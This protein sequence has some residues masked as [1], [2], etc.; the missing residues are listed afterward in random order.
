MAS[1]RAIP[2]ASVVGPSV[3]RPAACLCVC[4]SVCLLTRLFGVRS[5]GRSLSRGDEAQRRQSMRPVSTLSKHREC[6]VGREYREAG[7]RRSM[8]TSCC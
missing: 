3:F 8:R 6:N 5:I 1:L 7:T 2:S 4:L